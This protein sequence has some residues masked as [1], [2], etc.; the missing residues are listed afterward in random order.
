MK[1]FNYAS[2]T[3]I[4]LI[5]L[6]VLLR[7][8]HT[9][10]ENFSPVLSL[11]LMGSAYFTRRWMAFLFPAAI[12]FISDTQIGMEG[13]R[14]IEMISV[15]VSYLLITIGGLQLHN[16]V[17]PLRVIVT[18]F[19]S[20]LFFFLLTNFACWYGSAYYSQ[21]LKGL[22]FNYYGARYFYRSSLVSDVL[23]SGVLFTTFEMIRVKY[24]KFALL[25]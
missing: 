19:S 4:V 22:V 2:L 11:C 21:D 23:F 14:P 10:P 20:S 9:L 16:N 3:L 1:R 24:P 6:V 18:V 17:K 5:G 13:G 7:V 8:T 12:L 15:Y 25:K